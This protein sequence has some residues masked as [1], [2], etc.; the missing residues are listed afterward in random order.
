MIVHLVSNIGRTPDLTRLKS[1]KVAN[2]SIK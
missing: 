1:S 2:G